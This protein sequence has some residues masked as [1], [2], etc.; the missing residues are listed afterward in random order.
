MAARRTLVAVGSQ[1][2]AK[3]SGTRRAFSR[4][5]PDIELTGVETDSSVRPQPL[6]LDE[7]IQGALARAKQALQ[8]RRGVDY[9]VGIEAGLAAFGEESLNLQIAVVMGVSGGF[10]LGSSSGFMIPGTVVRQMQTSGV[11]LDRL[12]IGLGAR[13]ELGEEEG[14]VYPLTRGKVS[15]VDLVDQSVT[16][17]LIP[18]VNREI[19]LL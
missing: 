9:G 19:Y 13:E 16:M 3:T 12:A 14:V 1:N 2:P 17:A 6:T 8:A 7:T 15:R 4:F 5:F 10:S 11:E 18:W